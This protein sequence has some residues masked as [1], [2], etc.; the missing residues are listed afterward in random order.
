ME[1]QR[2]TDAVRGDF[3]FEPLA[4]QTVY[5]RLATCE[6]ADRDYLDYLAGCPRNNV[7]YE[8]RR[9]YRTLFTITASVR[10]KTIWYTGY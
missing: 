10:A 3:N 8:Y 1:L 5:D 2:F 7:L 9:Y 6:E 4:Y